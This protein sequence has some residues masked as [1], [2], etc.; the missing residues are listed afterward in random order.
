M[1]RAKLAP[2]FRWSAFVAVYFHTLPFLFVAFLL[3]AALFSYLQVF[4]QFGRVEEAIVITERGSSKS[5]GFGFVTFKK[6][7][8]AAKALAK[9]KEAEAL[10]KKLEVRVF[11][12]ARAGAG[13]RDWEAAASGVEA[14]LSSPELF[15]EALQ[16][17]DPALVKKMLK[18]A[19]ARPEQVETSD[20]AAIKSVFEKYDV[21]NSG[22]LDASS[23]SA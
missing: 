10:A 1:L 6:A 22:A 23:P 7:K 20:T 16:A 5:R 11:A 18:A 19:A 8:Y 13:E 15:A 21:D 9:T 14:A 4:E 17:A 3:V 12:E 2:L